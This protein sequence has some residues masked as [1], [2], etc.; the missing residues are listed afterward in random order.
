MAWRVLLTIVMKDVTPVVLTCKDYCGEN[1]LFH[2][3]C[4]RL[5][6]NLNTPLSNQLYHAIVKPCTV[7]TIKIRY[8]ST[9]YQMVE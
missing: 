9:S 6:T 7:K 1:L 8:N 4:P 5:P 3:H 2:L